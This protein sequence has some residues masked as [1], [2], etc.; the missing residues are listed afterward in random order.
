MDATSSG[1]PGPTSPMPP[2]ITVQ[3]LPKV[4]QTIPGNLLDNPQIV[5]CKI[6]YDVIR[7]MP[8]TDQT[9]WDALDLPTP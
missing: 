5:V 8:V 4:D 6:A 9:F 2:P 3:A 7:D 1:P